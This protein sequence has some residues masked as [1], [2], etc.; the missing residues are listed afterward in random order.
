MLK[1]EDISEATERRFWEKVR[2]TGNKGGCWVWGGAANSKGY[3]CIGWGRRGA[4]K[5]H[6]AHRVSFVLSGRTLDASLTIDHLCGVKRCVNPEHL[7]QVPNWVNNYRKKPGIAG[8]VVDLG[9]PW[10]QLDQNRA[11]FEAKKS[12]LS[13]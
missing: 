3:G 6:L 11:I 2:K 12:G 7:D 1:R 13:D 9:T 8:T 10:G 5:M 4:M